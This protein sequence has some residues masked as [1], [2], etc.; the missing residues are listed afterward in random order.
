MRNLLLIVTASLAVAIIWAA[1]Y[2][3]KQDPRPTEAHLVIF[4]NDDPVVSCKEPLVC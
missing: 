4:H 2:T 3:A 1:T